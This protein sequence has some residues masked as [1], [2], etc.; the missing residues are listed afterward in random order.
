MRLEYYVYVVAEK[1]RVI[2]AMLDGNRWRFAAEG[3]PLSFENV[4][5][6]NSRRTPDRFTTAMLEAYLVSLGIPRTDFGQCKVYSIV[7]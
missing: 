4:S 6:Y 5:I 7:T 1:T 3:E 2:C